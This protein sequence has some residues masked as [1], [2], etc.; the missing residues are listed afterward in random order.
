M[1]WRR[2]TEIEAWRVSIK[3]HEEFGA[4]LDRTPASKDRRF[5]EDARNALA[6]A[7][8]KIA[9]GFGRYSHREF[10]NFVNIARASHLETQ[11]NLILARDRQFLSPSEFEHLWAISEEAVAITT[12]LLK[13]LRRRSRARI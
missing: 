3:L 5:C 7:P 12:G 6:S 2:F 11:T 4:V 13:Y 1:G 8:R 9:E 10:A